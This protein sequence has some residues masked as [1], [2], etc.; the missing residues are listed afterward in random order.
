M[1]NKI[2]QGDVG[3]E[4]NVNCQEDLTS[5][6][7]PQILIKKPDGNVLTKPATISGNSLIYITVDGDLEQK[8]IYY[9]QPKLSLGGWSGSGVT[10]RFFVQPLFGGSE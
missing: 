3:L 8:G 4:I 6:T 1:E 10:T 2:Y 9:V 7:S 5:A